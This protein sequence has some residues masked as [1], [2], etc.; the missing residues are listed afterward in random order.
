[1]P[2]TTDPFGLL[3][4]GWI[5]N[6]TGRLPCDG[7]CMIEARLRCGDSVVDQAGMFSWAVRDDDSDI[8]EYRYL[9]SGVPLSDASP[10]SAASPR[11][12]LLSSKDTN[13]KDAIGARKAKVSVIPSGVMYELGLAMLEGAL[14]Y[15]RH[16]YRAAGVRASVYYD[17]A[18]GHLMDYWEGQD[19]DPDSGLSHLVKAMASLAVWIDALQ[20]GMCE[21]DRPP[22]SKVHKADFNAAAAEIIDRYAGKNPHHYT[23]KDEMK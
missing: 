1:M 20:Q 23:I 8:M 18:M 7:G 15:G 21:D 14:K 5:K 12:A 9:G 4:M 16:N 3:E 6:V 13:P 22:R 11:S 2:S 17:A 19:I 10:T